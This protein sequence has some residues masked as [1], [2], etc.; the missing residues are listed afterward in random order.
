MSHEQIVLA[1]RLIKEVCHAIANAVGNGAQGKKWNFLYSHLLGRISCNV[2][3]HDR[4]RLDARRQIVYQIR[5]E[6]LRYTS[7]VWYE[8]DDI[9]GSDS[10]QD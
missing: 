4:E 6:G 7:V 9:H 8:I 10:L 3:G 1:L 5:H 2:A